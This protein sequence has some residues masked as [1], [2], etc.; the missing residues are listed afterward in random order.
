MRFPILVSPIWRPFLLIA[1]VSPERAY[2][3]IDDGVLYVRFGLFRHQFPLS[4]VESAAKADWPL[5]GGIGWRATWLGTVGIIGTYVN[6]VRLQFKERQRV[7][8][9]MLPVPCDRLSLSMEN[10]RAFL[11][12]LSEFG[13]STATNA[14]PKSATK[15]RANHRPKRKTA[16]VT[17]VEESSTN[18]PS[19]DAA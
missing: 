2:V 16:R 1:G 4:H 7:Q 13:V 6:V 10:P 19:D 14:R 12:A 5:W 18:G 8:A 17:T 3:D 15:R 9:L 11:A